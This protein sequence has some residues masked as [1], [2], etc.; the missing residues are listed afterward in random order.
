MDFRIIML[1]HEATSLERFLHS[2]DKFVA[3]ETIQ[4]EKTAKEFEDK[5][6]TFDESTGFDPNDYLADLAYEV[7]EL[8]ELA[9]GSFV[10]RVMISIEQALIHLARKEQRAKN[11]IFGY[12]DIV[13][14]RGIG[15]TLNYLRKIFA[16]DEKFPMDTEMQDS[17][18]ASIIVRNAIMHAD[19]RV[20]GKENVTKLKEFV[21][22]HGNIIKFSSFSK[23]EES[24]KITI[25]QDYAKLL[26]G[27]NRNLIRAIDARMHSL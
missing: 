16:E 6:L 11:Q 10:I 7:S 21:R 23:N 5:N 14:S 1:E 8:E 19:A 3:E 25:T 26:I 9:L 18:D 4:L 2:I 15:Q 13:G 22:K 27:L 17:L 12:G 20:R 24:V